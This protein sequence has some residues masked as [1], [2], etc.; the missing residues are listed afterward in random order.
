[1]AQYNPLEVVYGG[2]KRQY[3]VY[4]GELYTKQFPISWAETH[5]LGTGPKECLNCDTYGTWNGVFI[6]YCGNCAQYVYEGGRGCGFIGWG[7]EG[8]KKEGEEDWI[9]AFD[10]YLLG[11]NLDDIGDTDFCDSRVLVEY[12]F[13]NCYEVLGEEY[14]AEVFKDEYEDQ[15]EYQEEE[16]LEITWSYDTNR[17]TKN[18]YDSDDEFDYDSDKTIVDDYEELREKYDVVIIPITKNPNDTTKSISLVP[19]YDDDVDD[20]EEEKDNEENDYSEWDYFDA[21]DEYECGIGYSYGYGSNY[22]DGYD[23][24]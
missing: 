15:E 7:E 18:V 21:P 24:F 3:Y 10:T 8:V 19:E 6:G 11:V 22:N 12:N 5:E 1:M 16:E 20:E 13:T 17:L 2:N 9:R 23:S 14:A 4:D